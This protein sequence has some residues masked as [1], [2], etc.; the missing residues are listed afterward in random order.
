[1]PKSFAGIKDFSGKN[2]RVSGILSKGDI[3]FSPA[4][5]FNFEI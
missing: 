4:F 2:R 1:M 3:S 5:S